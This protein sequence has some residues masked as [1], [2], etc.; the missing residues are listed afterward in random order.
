MVGWTP[1]GEAILYASTAE[2]PFAARPWLWAVSP[3]A[4]CRGRLP[5]GPASGSSPTARAAAMV[6]GR[7]TADP[8][9]WK[10]YRGGT[11]GD[12]WIDPSGTGEFH[13][14]DHAGRQPGQPVLGRRPRLLPVRPRGRRQRLLLPARRLGPAPPH[15][16]RRLLRPPPE[17][18]TA[19]G[20]STTPAPT[21]TCSTRPPTSR[22]RLAIDLA[23]SR[24][25]RNRRFV[26]AG[27]FLHSATLSPDGAGLAITTPRQGVHASPTGTARS[28]STASPTACATGC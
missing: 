20:W 26:P 5:F 22:A 7:N 19:R 18:P 12:L 2:R 11:A 8:A 1:D 10:R 4:A 16:P 3:T 13:A 24:T 28:A 9:R 14:A 6:L 27:T 25:Q 15:R 23:S 21:C 17:Q